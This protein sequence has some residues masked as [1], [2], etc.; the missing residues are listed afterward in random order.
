LKIAILGAGVTGLTL[1]QLLDQDGFDVHVLEKSPI[2][3]GLCRSSNIDGFTCDHAGGHILFS[4]DQ[5]VLAWMKEQVGDDNLVEKDRNTKI[6]WHDRWVPYPFENGVGHLTPEARFDCLKGYLESVERRKSGEACPEDFASWIQWKMGAGFAKHFMVPYNEKIWSGDLSRMSSGWVAGRVPDAPLD[7]ILKAA[8]GIDTAGYKHQALF[9]FP[10]EGGF[11]A[12]TDGILSK[13]QDKVRLSTPVQNLRRKGE[14]FSVNDED[15]D[16]VINTIP[17][18]ELAKVFEDLPEDVAEDIQ[19]LQ[20]ISLVNVLLGF[21]ADQPLDDLSWI[22]L[23]FEDQGPANRVTYY[24]NYSP[25]NAPPG[26]A[27]FMAEVTYRGT[28]DV[29]EAWIGDLSQG[30]ENAGILKRSDLVTTHSF[31]SPYAYIDQDLAF[32]DRIKRV[33][34]W[35]DSSGLFTVGRFG[36]YEY[37]NSDQCISRAMEVREQVRAMGRSGTFSPLQLA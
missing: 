26:H 16:F 11:Q 20:P 28:L 24:S 10:L 22:Y 13:V 1:A 19:H 29:D 3:G 4:K 34:D 25:R 32:P 27:S 23:P 18:P 36:R 6:R 33:R 21:K 8:V 14:G 5:K 17:L 9:W 12:L 30:L 35:F 31:H 37:H 7:D 2:A 15:F